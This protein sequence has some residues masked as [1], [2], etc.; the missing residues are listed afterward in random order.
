MGRRGPPPQPTALRELAGNP[1][2]RPLPLGEP[3]PATE[4]PPRRRLFRKYALLVIALVGTALLVN[5]G[6]DFWFSYRENK[7]ALVRIQQEK[8]CAG[9]PTAS[10]LSD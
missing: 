1:S 10:A 2:H 5:S 4:A 9:L 3:K 6:F 7:A 8:V